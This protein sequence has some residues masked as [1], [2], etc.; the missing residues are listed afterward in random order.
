MSE[1]KVHAEFF[2]V[3]A[4]SWEV[5]ACARIARAWEK[6]DRLYVWAASQAEAARWD[7]LLWTFRED[8]FVPHGLWQGEEA[9]D[10]PV[11]VGWRAANPNGARWLVVAGGQTPAE[12]TA[13]ASSFARIMDFVPKRDKAATDAARA[14]YKALQ[15]A[16]IEPAYHKAG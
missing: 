14:R 9:C 16:G 13:A 2:E 8:S 3:T 10:E 1:S 4:P 5:E 6:G 15:Q 7:E 11:A 12:V